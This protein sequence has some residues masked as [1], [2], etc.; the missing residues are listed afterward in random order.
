MAD[1]PAGT[2]ELFSV[3]FFLIVAHACLSRTNLLR[4]ALA[5]TLLAINA[6]VALISSGSAFRFEMACV[7]PT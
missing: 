2:I 4:G 7:W 6:G 1:G 5:A 3:S